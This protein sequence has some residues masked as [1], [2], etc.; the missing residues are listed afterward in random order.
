MQ[1]KGVALIDK[2]TECELESEFNPTISGSIGR[3]LSHLLFTT[4]RQTKA[5][6]EAKGT[7]REL[8]FCGSRTCRLLSPVCGLPV[9]ESLSFAFSKSTEEQRGQRFAAAKS[10]VSAGARSASLGW[11]RGRSGT[12]S[13]VLGRDCWL[14]AD[15]AGQCDELRRVLG[16]K[17]PTLSLRDRGA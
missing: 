14:L 12:I 17:L 2:T 15:G 1:H 6:D 5:I 13:I 7:T 8:S 16:N 10:I 4:V 11:Q 3:P 9:G